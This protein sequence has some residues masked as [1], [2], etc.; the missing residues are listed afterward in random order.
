MQK[1]T[2]AMILSLGLAAG[3]NV[4]A[5]Q[6]TPQIVLSCTANIVDSV[7]GTT[8][9]TYSPAFTL[10]PG[11]PFS[12]DVSNPLRF[13][14]FNASVAWNANRTGVD[15]TIDYNRDRGV[16]EFG[17][18]RAQLPMANNRSAQS[19]SGYSE[20]DVVSGSQTNYLTNYQLTCQRANQ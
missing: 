17:S 15:V 4:Q 7:N 8:V 18:F 6:G 10:T 9:F 11:N 2:K 20:S 3:A 12:E 5:A 1:L 13:G 14:S 16:F 19:I